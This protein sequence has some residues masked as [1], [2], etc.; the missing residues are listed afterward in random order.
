MFKLVSDET[1]IYYNCQNK[2][3]GIQV[4]HTDAAV[5]PSCSMKKYCFFPAPSSL[6]PTRTLMLSEEP[7]EKNVISARIPGPGLCPLTRGACS[8]QRQDATRRQAEGTKARWRV[9]SSSSSSI[10]KYELRKEI[11]GWFCLCRKGRRAF[12][13]WMG[14]KIEEMEDLQGHKEQKLHKGDR[15]HIFRETSLPELQHRSMWLWS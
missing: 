6:A 1:T 13:P 12:S 10:K 7:M 9:H 8:I 14:W 2:H 5:S 15:R 4:N 11:K 3:A